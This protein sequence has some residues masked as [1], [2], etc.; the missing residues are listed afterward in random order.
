MSIIYWMIFGMFLVTYIPRMMPMVFTKD[1]IFPPLL[2][3]WLSY[4]P[5]AALGAL[6]FPGVLTVDANYPWI[7]LVAA[8]IAFI[9]AWFFKQMILVLLAAVLVVFLLQ[10]FML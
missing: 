8:V 5:Y 4:I 10:Q 9:I 6:I 3:K 1:L 7:G 2:E